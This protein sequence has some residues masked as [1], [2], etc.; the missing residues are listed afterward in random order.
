M[1]TASSNNNKAFFLLSFFF[2]FFGTNIGQS[3]M[4]LK[5]IGI[6]V[7]IGLWMKLQYHEALEG[8]HKKPYI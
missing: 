7:V 4:N 6:Y 2:F 1:E 3:Y 5:I 8:S